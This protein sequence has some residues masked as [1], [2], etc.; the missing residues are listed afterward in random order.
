MN[1]LK[2]VLIILVVV[3]L[4]A[5]NNVEDCNYLK[6]RSIVLNFMVPSG[7]S[8]KDTLINDIVIKTSQGKT[9]Y[10]TASNLS[11]NSIVVKQVTLPLSQNTDTSVFYFVFGNKAID[12]I[13]F[14]VERSLELISTSCGFNTRFALDSIKSTKNIIQSIQ[15]IDYNIG[16]DKEHD[17]NANII[18][19]K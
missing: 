17:R 14:F 5:C 3:I 2:T 19:K 13:S 6:N 11:T 7:K 12:T 8:Y 1:L 15:I 18:L 16:E 10:D 4:L 9:I